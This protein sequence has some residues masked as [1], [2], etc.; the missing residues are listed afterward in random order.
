[1]D[2]ELD[3]TQVILSVKAKVST[4]MPNEEPLTDANNRN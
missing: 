1:M 4:N 2:F 3:N